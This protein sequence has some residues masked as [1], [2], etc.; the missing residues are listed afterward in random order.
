MR[1]KS[2]YFVP[3]LRGVE[4]SKDKLKYPVNPES[5]YPKAFFEAKLLLQTRAET[6]I[7]P[8]HFTISTLDLDLESEYL[9]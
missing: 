2:L 5:R 6:Y 1:K 9:S 4:E 3:F 8:V 7:Y